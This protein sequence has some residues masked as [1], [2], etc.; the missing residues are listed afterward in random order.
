MAH[1]Q[2]VIHVWSSAWRTFV[3]QYLACLARECRPRQRN[4]SDTLQSV[5][6]AAHLSRTAYQP[7]TILLK[8]GALRI[9]NCVLLRL[10][11]SSRVCCRRVYHFG[12]ETFGLWSLGTNAAVNVQTMT[13]PWLGSL[14]LVRSRTSCAAVALSPIDTFWL[15]R[16]NE[17][18]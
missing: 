3:V 17:A 12:S 7:I 11:W 9:L 5:H 4:T 18:R 6:R 15:V 14:W 10:P 13:D 1:E 8:R 2:L 16:Q